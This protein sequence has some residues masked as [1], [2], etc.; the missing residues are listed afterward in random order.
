MEL[1]YEKKINVVH[2]FF[3]VITFHFSAQLTSYVYCDTHSYIYVA[4][5]NN[6]NLVSTVDRGHKRG[7]TKSHIHTHTFVHSHVC[8]AQF[9]DLGLPDNKYNK[10]D[11][12][13]DASRVHTY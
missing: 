3:S 4:K 7:D 1:K 12:I 11:I 13:K 10:I 2:T 8:E 5:K 6:G 9:S